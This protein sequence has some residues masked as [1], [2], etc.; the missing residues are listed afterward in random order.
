[1]RAL[2][3]CSVPGC[4]ELVASGRCE[5]CDAKAE[6]KRGSSSERGYGRIHRAGFRRGV[7]KIQPLCQCR[8]TQ[9][10]HSAP[11]LIPSTVADHHPRDRRELTR[12]GLNANDPQYGRGLCASCHNKHTAKAQPGGFLIR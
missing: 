4:P 6:R 1:M 10:G 3:T 9:H 12:L 2:K 11:C 7:L 5:G 8:D